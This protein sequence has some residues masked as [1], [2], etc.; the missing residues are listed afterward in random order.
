MIDIVYAKLI[1]I[2]DAERREQVLAASLIGL[3]LLAIAYAI[4]QHTERK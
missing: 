3:G 4:S 1:S 2:A